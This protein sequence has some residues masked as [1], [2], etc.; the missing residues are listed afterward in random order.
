MV[1]DLKKYEMKLQTVDLM[2]YRGAVVR[3]AGMMVES[4]GPP[5]ELPHQPGTRFCLLKH[6]LSHKPGLA[7]LNP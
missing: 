2:P 1:V 7:R 3:V 6:S 5:V 4:K